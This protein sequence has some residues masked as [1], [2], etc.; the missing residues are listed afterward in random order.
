MNTSTG[1]GATGPW[2]SLPEALEAPLNIGLLTEFALHKLGPKW[3]KH[4]AALKAAIELVLPG[5]IEEAQDHFSAWAFTPDNVAEANRW[6]WARL[7]LAITEKMQTVQDAT[8]PLEVQ[9]ARALAARF[10]PDERPVMPWA[11]QKDSGDRQDRRAHDGH[12]E[13]YRSMWK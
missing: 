4:K 11:E 3:S 13:A 2:T 10:D 8:E 6:I 1:N 7:G 5:L 9:R 12:L